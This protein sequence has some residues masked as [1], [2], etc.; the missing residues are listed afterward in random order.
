MSAPP[1][2][3]SKDANASAGTLFPLPEV[4]ENGTK[5]LEDGDGDNAFEV[6]WE[7]GDDPANP[8]SLSTLRKWIVVL[9]LSVSSLCVSV[10]ML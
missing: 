9:I 1:D 6:R 3:E 4:T 2:I 10:V 7:G 8:R 5:C